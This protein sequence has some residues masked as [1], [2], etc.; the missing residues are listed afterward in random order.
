MTLS[1]KRTDYA[2]DIGAARVR[3]FEAGKGVV[4]DVPVEDL[5][6]VYKEQIGTFT[7]RP[8]GSPEFRNCILSSRRWRLRLVAADR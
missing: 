6:D 8:R 2:L 4:L 7:K 1:L 3:A 5:V